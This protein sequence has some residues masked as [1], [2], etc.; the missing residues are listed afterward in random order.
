[1]AILPGCSDPALK[2]LKDKGYNVVQLPKADLLPTQLLVRN[3]KRLQRL[4]DLTSVFNPDPQAPVPPIS[5]DKGG[6][7]ISG[8]SSADLDVGVGLNIL[9]GLISALG[10]STLGLTMGYQRARSV[11]FEYVDTIENHAQV[12]AIDA[13]LAGATINPFARAVAQMLE[14]DNVYVIT[15]TLKAKKLNVSAKDSSKAS[16]AV[17]VPVIQNAIGGNVKLTS[18]GAG[19]TIV[20]YEGAVPLVFGIQAVRLIFENGKY[21]SMKLVDSGK[22]SLEAAAEQGG[23]IPVNNTFFANPEVMLGGG[24]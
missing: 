12:S 20:T 3:G 24:L 22:V 13:F 16:L 21:R 19:S 17:D 14:A 9:G 1:M 11:Q 8:T 7:N 4:G 10:G 18:S 23:D 5:A 6:P 2:A 15:S